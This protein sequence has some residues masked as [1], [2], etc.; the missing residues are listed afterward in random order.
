[1]I[2]ILRRSEVAVFEDVLTVLTEDRKA[3]CI[4]VGHKVE[5]V[6]GLVPAPF[7]SDLVAAA[8]LHDVGYG[9]PFTGFHPLD[10]AAFLAGEGFGRLICHLVA[11]HSMSPLEAEVRGLNLSAYDEY[12]VDVATSTLRRLEAIICWADMTTGPAGG[13]VLVETRL[14]EIVSRYGPDDV[15]TRFI[16]RARPALV[17]AGQS[18]LSMYGAE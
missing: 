6:A 14:E 15:V 9:H 12:R 3:H 8:T 7:R 16:E 17:R 2:R 5:S 18:P 11:F 1:M 4:E 10:G 13:T